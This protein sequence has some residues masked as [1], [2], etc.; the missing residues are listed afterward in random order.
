MP[1][2]R[3]VASNLRAPSGHFEPKCICV[4]HSRSNGLR[5]ILVLAINLGDG[6]EN[7]KFPRGY[8]GRRRP[9]VLTS[10]PLNF[11][12]SKEYV[13]Q[14][15]TGQE[16]TVNHLNAIRLLK[17]LVAAGASSRAPMDSDWVHEIALRNSSLQVTD[18]ASAIACA[19]RER[20][21]TDSR[22]RNDWIYLTPTGEVVGK[23]P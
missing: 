2:L 22:T 23:L 20:W 18:L 7:Y 6:L 13:A 11:W 10:H 14:R 9:R 17:S 15:L 8:C 16:S 4:L 1:F 19:E 5:H 21:L 12:V 3:S